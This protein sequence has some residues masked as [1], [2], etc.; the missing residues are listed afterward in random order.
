MF[1]NFSTSTMENHQR[2]QVAC[3]LLQKS[4]Y[5]FVEITSAKQLRELACWSRTYCETMLRLFKDKKLRLLKAK[6]ISNK[7]SRIEHIQVVRKE[8]EFSNRHV[9]DFVVKSI[10]KPFNDFVDSNESSMLNFCKGIEGVPLVFAHTVLGTCVMEYLGAASHSYKKYKYSLN[11]L[12]EICHIV[13]RLH[14][15]CST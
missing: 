12:L 10:T 15:R 7:R 11:Q 4:C 8:L 5:K 13:Q 1:H 2:I 3:S 9:R 14:K 6:V